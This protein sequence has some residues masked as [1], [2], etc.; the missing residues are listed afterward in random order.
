MIQ[1]WYKRIK[2]KR[3]NLL[4]STKD[5]IDSISWLQNDWTYSRVHRALTSLNIAGM[6]V[7]FIFIFHSIF[8]KQRKGVVSFFGVENLVFLYIFL[9]CSFILYIFTNFIDQLYIQS[10]LWQLKYKFLYQTFTN[11]VLSLTNFWDTT[12]NLGV[13]SFPIVSHFLV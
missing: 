8:W 6:L 7:L 3:I 5:G 4:R 12:V 11:I 9:Y 2:W 13:I 10:S 1:L